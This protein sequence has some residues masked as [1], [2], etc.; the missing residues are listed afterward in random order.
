MSARQAELRALQEEAA[1]GIEEVVG[2]PA[3]ERRAIAAMPCSL[4]S[5]S[6][7]T[8][9]GVSSIATMTSSCENSSRLLL[10]AEPH[11]EADLFEHAEQ[12]LAVADDRFQLF[13]QLHRDGCTG[14]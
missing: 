14:P 12:H 4:P 3:P 11:V 10:V 1:I 13:A 5:I 9:T 6:T 2:R 8:P 7:N